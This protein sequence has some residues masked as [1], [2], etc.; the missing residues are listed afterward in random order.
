[1]TASRSGLGDLVFCFFFPPIA[2]IVEKQAC[3][4]NFHGLCAVKKGP[5]GKILTGTKREREKKK[6]QDCGE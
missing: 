1:M 4:T 5:E 3:P 2:A 6:S